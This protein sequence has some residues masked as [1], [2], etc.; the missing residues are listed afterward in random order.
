MV[1][2]MLYEKVINMPC[3]YPAKRHTLKYYLT[4]LEPL[5]SVCLS[6]GHLCLPNTNEQ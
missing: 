2:W 3:K 1:K 5:L 4:T 6:Y